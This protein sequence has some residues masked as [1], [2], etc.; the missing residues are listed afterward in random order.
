MSW[1]AIIFRELLDP[2]PR[3]GDAPIPYVVPLEQPK[4]LGNG[5]SSYMEALNKLAA[6]AWVLIG[7]CGPEQDDIQLSWEE[8]ELGS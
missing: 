6:H 5:L 4:P 2:I 3:D 7:V 1:Y 8:W